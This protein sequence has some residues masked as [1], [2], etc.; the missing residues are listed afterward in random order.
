[1]AGVDA[2]LTLIGPGAPRVGGECCVP[3]E[4]FRSPAFQGWYTAQRAAGNELRSARVEWVLRTGPK[5]DWL[6]LWALLVDV[7]VRAEGRRKA[8]E[9]VLGRAD[10][11]Q[12]VML[13]RSKNPLDSQVVLVREFRSAAR[14][15][16]GSV[17]ETPGGSSFEGV[18]DPLPLAVDEVAEETG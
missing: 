13:H 10:A 16:D 12:V 15:A 8:S 5:K 2:A 7:F 9:V 6:F 4:I 14:T 3:A 11:S 1:E 17:H 18:T